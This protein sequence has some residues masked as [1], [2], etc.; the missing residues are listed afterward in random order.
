MID[1]LEFAGLTNGGDLFEMVSPVD[2][3]ETTPLI[4]AERAENI[5]TGTL[6]CA[7]E[8]FGFV[9]EDIEFGEGIFGCGGKFLA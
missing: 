4:D 3:L 8:S 2:E 5:V 1:D 7:E 6:T 9:A